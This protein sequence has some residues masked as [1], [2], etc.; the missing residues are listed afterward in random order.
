[1]DRVELRRMNALR[2]GSITNTGQELRESVGLVECIDKAE[3][4]MCRL[5]QLE[6]WDQIAFCL[7]SC[8]GCAAF[9]ARLGFRGRLQKHRPGRRRAG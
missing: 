2:V 4:E 3:A 9:E 6:G 5:A 7:T 1:M 8:A